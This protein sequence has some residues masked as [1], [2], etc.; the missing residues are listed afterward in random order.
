[1]ATD[2]R[3]PAVVAG[4]GLA[5]SPLS[6][7]EGLPAALRRT[8]RKAARC[9]GFSS[10]PIEIAIEIG[11]EIAR[12]T[13]NDGLIFSSPATHASRYEGHVFQLRRSRFGSRFRFR[14]RFRFLRG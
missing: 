6:A 4:T 5:P 11:I 9:G 2:H 13:A 7:L 10:R 12:L 3:G 1:V 14:F 8:V